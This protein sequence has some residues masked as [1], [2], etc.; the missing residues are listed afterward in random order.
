MHKNF[1]G[2]HKRT[3]PTDM[4]GFYNFFP[5]KQLQVIFYPQKILQKVCLKICLVA[6]VEDN[7]KSIA[8]AK[9][10][11]LHRFEFAKLV[12]V[13]GIGGTLGC[14]LPQERTLP[15]GKTSEIF[16]NGVQ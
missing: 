3:N 16:K 13:S 2:M 7:R 6:N 8:Q 10:F 11:V 14:I 12:L 4:F 15:V 1:L 9:V 5:V